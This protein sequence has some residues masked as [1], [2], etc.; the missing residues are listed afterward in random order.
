[1]LNSYLIVF[2]AG[3]DDKVQSALR[4]ISAKP[5]NVTLDEFMKTFDDVTKAPSLR[6]IVDHSDKR[7]TQE[8]RADFLFSSIG[9]DAVIYPIRNGETVDFENAIYGAKVDKNTVYDPGPDPDPK[10]FAR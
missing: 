4:S 1:M 7:I 8:G 2:N 3:Y 6:F 9:K 5:K 10:L